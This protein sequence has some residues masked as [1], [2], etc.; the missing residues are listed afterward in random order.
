[1]VV[2]ISEG[3]NASFYFPLIPFR[4]GRIKLLF[5]NGPD[6]GCNDPFHFYPTLTV[7]R[8]SRQRAL[9]PFFRFYECDVVHNLKL[10]LNKPIFLNMKKLAEERKLFN[11]TKNIFLYL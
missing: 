3:S 6:D 11:K 1:M 10:W 9:K 5:E 4:R 8:K 7:H 2:P